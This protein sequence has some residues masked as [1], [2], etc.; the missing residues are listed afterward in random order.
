MP[1]S[2][3]QPPKTDIERL[4]SKLWFTAVSLQSGMNASQLER[5]FLVRSDPANGGTKELSHD[6]LRYSSGKRLPR[7]TRGSNNSVVTVVDDAFPGTAQ[8]I[9]SPLWTLLKNPELSSRELIDLITQTHQEIG[10][11]F[12]YDEVPTVSAKALT[13]SVEN[14]KYLA[15]IMS[16]EVFGIMLAYYRLRGIHGD[17]FNSI[18][19]KDCRRWLHYA[20]SRLPSIREHRDELVFVLQ[21]FAPELGNL[22]Y[23][24]KEV[25]DRDP[26][27][28]MVMSSLGYDF[29]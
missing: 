10:K 26:F 28:E 17:H 3:G 13:I 8:W 18:C 7:D 16:F 19:L 29:E 23:F 5:F 27:A 9:R 21:K 22:S 14:W 6:W 24:G 12:V 20:H 4:Q 2:R 15:R 1:K 25:P 11:L